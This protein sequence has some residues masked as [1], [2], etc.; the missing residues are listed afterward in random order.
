VLLKAAERIAL[1]EREL[2]ES[3]LPNLPPA[4]PN[5]LAKIDPT[6]LTPAEVADEL[7]GLA[8]DNPEGTV[9]YVRAVTPDELAGVTDGHV[10]A[11]WSAAYINDLPDS[12]F[13]C[14][15]P[16]GTKDA[17]GKTTPRNLR[18]FPYKDADGTIDIPH[19][20]NALARIPQSDLDDAVKNRLT[21]TGERILQGQSKKADEVDEGSDTDLTRSADPLRRKADAVELEF[22]TDGESLKKA[23]PNKPANRPDLVP[24]EDLRQRMRDEMLGALSGGLES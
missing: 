22:R 11:V 24:L 6:R 5:P 16:G 20:R 15:E 19:L 12:A 21:R 10:K 17:D 8:F 14:I 13:L 3:G 1:L 18:Y 2:E 4:P 23:Q 7:H 9:L